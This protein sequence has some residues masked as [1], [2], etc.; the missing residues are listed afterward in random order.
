MG[1]SPRTTRARA[2]RRTAQSAPTAAQEQVDPGSL[3]AGRERGPDANRTLAHMG[4]INSQQAQEL[5]AANALVDELEAEAEEY[6]ETIA[7]LQAELV[8]ATSGEG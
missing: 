3:P 2:N 4:R 7:G 6:R 1:N 5:A 8:A